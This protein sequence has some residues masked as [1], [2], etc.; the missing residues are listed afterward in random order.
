[1]ENPTVSSVTIN[2]ETKFRPNRNNQITNKLDD[3]LNRYAN[4]GILDT[5]D[6]GRKKYKT[7]DGRSVD[8]ITIARNNE[9]GYSFTP[10]KTRTIK[11]RTGKIMK[12]KAGKEYHIPRR[13]AFR[14]SLEGEYLKEIEKKLTSRV[15][16]LF[17]AKES[18]KRSAINAWKDMA[19]I[20]E[21]VIKKSYKDSEGLASNS[22]MTQALKGFNHPLTETGQ[23]QDA[24]THRIKLRSFNEKNVSK[25]YNPNSKYK[26]SGKL[27]Q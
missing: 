18:K 15:K 1:M 3:F 14:R 27:I 13:P 6:S 8:I 7:S 5:K 9:F 10:K 11:G 2:V 17:T 22:L 24:I 26:W 20:V 12:L 25:F 16:R 23:V 21:D 19:K 4:I